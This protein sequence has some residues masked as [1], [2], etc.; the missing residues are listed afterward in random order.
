MKKNLSDT[1]KYLLSALLTLALLPAS[2]QTVLYEDFTAGIPSD[3]TQYGDSNTA[4]NATY[5]TPWSSI[6]TRGNPAPCA[7]STSWF[8]EPQQA[9]RWLI[10]PPLVIPDTGYYLTFDMAC[11][12]NAY[13]DG[14]ELRISTQGDTSRALFHNTPLLSVARCSSS[15]TE[16]RVNLSDYAG[17]TIHLAFVQN[18]TDCNLL[19]LDNVFVG[20]PAVHEIALRDIAVPL[21]LTLNEEGF[22]SGRVENRGT[23]TLRSFTVC[24]TVNHQDWGT[25]Q[26]N[27][28]AVPH[29][30]SFSFTHTIPLRSALMG[31][32]VVTV[33]V[34][35][36]NGVTDDSTDNAMQSTLLVFDSNLCVARTPLVELLVMDS[37]GA[38]PSA[39]HQIDESLL[40]AGE[41]DAIVLQHH[42]GVGTDALS[43]A[44]GADLLMLYGEGAL[45]NPAVLY[46]RTHFD[47][48]FPGPAQ[49][50]S[51]ALSDRIQSVQQAAAV[52]TFVST[53]L[54]DVTFNATN[55]IVTGQL[56]GHVNY[57]D[58]NAALHYTIYLV[59]DSVLM[60][61]LTTDGWVLDFRHLNTVRSVIATGSLNT[62]TNEAGA[63]QVDFTATVPDSLRAWR[64]RLVTVIA[65]VDTEHI[66]NN[67]VMNATRSDYFDDTYVG[68]APVSDATAISLYPNPAH[69]VVW[70]YS[71]QPLH[72]VV[73]LN[74]MGQTVIR[75]FAEDTT[76]L[77][78]NVSALP[79][80]VYL[81]AVYTDAGRHTQRLMV[82]R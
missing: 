2:A 50:V 46:D 37:C 49:G 31:T 57:V 24:C 6:V 59:E 42:V 52:P 15:F 39:V 22:I 32:F 25:T 3:W 60:P 43:T 38:C 45:F 53:T 28:I 11:F 12:E 79:T 72:Q 51:S 36:P 65:N 41:T 35:N 73:V 63:Y 14:F 8:T 18:S 40:Q 23:D 82:V 7:A 48:T 26:I 29:G 69:D 67:R 78:L 71:E 19:L 17:E 4:H 34:N 33:S 10:T 9:D 77:R 68:I 70:I 44:A 64:C 54:T 74:A 27:N 81:V 1:K 80:G 56:S 20:I 62:V 66:D 58:P 30:G 21:S 47:H 75:Y 76:S 5:Q 61:Q 16:Y 13:P 55:R